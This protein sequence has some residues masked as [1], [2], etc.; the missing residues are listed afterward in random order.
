MI[1]IA[2]TG[3]SGRMGQTLIEAIEQTDGV[4]LGVKLDKGDDLSAVLD[5]FSAVPDGASTLWR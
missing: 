3:V 4:V 1:K 2:V 5:Q